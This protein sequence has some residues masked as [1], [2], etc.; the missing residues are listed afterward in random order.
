MN[1][2]WALRKEEPKEVDAA[3]HAYGSKVVRRLVSFRDLLVKKAYR[4]Q[5]SS[6][7]GVPT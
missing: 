5:S 4:C 2:K 7:E 3:M 1:L 6:L